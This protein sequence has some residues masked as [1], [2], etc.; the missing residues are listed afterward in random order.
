MSSRV[1]RASLLRVVDGVHNRANSNALFNLT[2]ALFL[3]AFIRARR[4]GRL[5]SSLYIKNSIHYLNNASL[6]S[7]TVG[8]TTH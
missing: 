6:H 1:S 7:H 2:D 4:G 5:L 3:N 8:G